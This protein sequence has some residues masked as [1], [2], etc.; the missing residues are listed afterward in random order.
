MYP[1]FSSLSLRHLH[2]GVMSI[3]IWWM[4]GVQV[5]KTSLSYTSAV[6]SQQYGASLKLCELSKSIALLLVASSTWKL[7]LTMSQ[8]SEVDKQ[9][10]I[11][12]AYDLTA[13]YPTP[14]GTPLFVVQH[15]KDVPEKPAFIVDDQI[16]TVEEETHTER[17]K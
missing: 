15:G 8:F 11:M 1:Q 7:V 13:D 17:H 14:A 3:L 6:L 4:H 9:F 2:W 12:Q 5:V 16:R 10:R